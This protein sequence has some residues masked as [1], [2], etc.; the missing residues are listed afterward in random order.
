[1]IK[2]TKNNIFTQNAVSENEK[3]TDG[4]SSNA[5]A[6]KRMRKEIIKPVS[7]RSLSSQ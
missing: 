5:T 4:G 6:F 1:M 7:Y 2:K 3:R